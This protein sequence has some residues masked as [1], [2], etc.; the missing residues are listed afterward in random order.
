[1]FEPDITKWIML[2]EAGL[3]LGA[4]L[5]VFGL[6]ALA[7]AALP[8]RARTRPRTERWAINL[9]IT[10]LNTLAVRFILPAGALGAALWCEAHGVGIF[11]SAPMPGLFAGLASIVILDLAIYTQH[12]VFHRFGPLWRLHM[13][14]HADLDIDVTTGARFHPIEILLSMGIKIALI[15]A[16]GAPGWAV[17][18]FEVVLNAMAMFNHA[19]LRLPLW[20]DRG[21]RLFVVTPDMHR[22]HHSV[23]PRELNSNFGFNLSMWD[24][25]FRTYKPEPEAGHEG[26]TIG[27][28]HFREPERLTLPLIIAMPFKARKI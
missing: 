18:A 14:H 28:A 7:E 6:M 4:F 13:V 21:L 24:R 27:L 26:M 19:N 25:L 22:V 16:L 20:L 1:M 3:R 5:G 17:V 15:A 10:L 23:I 9:G 2:H 11:N 12:V 8:R